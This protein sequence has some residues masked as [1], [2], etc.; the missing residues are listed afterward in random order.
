[1]KGERRKKRKKFG[2]YLYAVV[3]LF[4]T[5][6]NIL[7]G[8]WLLTRVQK[9]YVSGTEVSEKT[10][11]IDWISEDPLTVNSIYT[12]VKFKIGS[13]KLP[14]YLSDVQVKLSAPWTVRV[15]VKEK[16]II[17]CIVDGQEYVYFDQDG[18]VLKKTDEYDKSVP[19]IEGIDVKDTVLFQTM[20][21]KNKKIFSYVKNITQELEN[22]KLKPERIVWEED[23][24]DLYF[25]DVCV[26]LG[27]SKYGLRVKQLQSVLHELEGEKGVLHLEHYT[28][29]SKSF[30]FEKK[31]EEIDEKN[32]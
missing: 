25:S 13:Y 32:Y 5:V 3:I 23:S 8:M 17:A 19:I 22:T 12:F 18:L 20:K 26:K 9:I 14:V 30:S 7:L 28:E 27:K 31:N 4:L 29:T 10:E 1:M 11:I 15:E 24:M 6:A 2:Y 16:Q 21:V